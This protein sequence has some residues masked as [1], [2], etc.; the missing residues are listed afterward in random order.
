MYQSI[1][2]VRDIGNAIPGIDMMNCPARKLPLILVVIFL[3]GC[4]TGPG[5][6]DPRTGMTRSERNLCEAM[7]S[8]EPYKPGECGE[9]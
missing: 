1:L 9:M 5:P 6:V 4:A 7:R 3:T 2:N 8:F